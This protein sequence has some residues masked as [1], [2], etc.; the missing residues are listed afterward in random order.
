M[1]KSTRTKPRADAIPWNRKVES[2]RAEISLPDVLEDKMLIYGNKTVQDRAVNDYRDGFKPVHRRLIWTMFK[3]GLWSKGGFTKSARVTGTAMGLFHP[4]S[5]SALYEALVTL[6]NLRYSLL[7]KQG[8]WGSVTGDLPAAERYSEVKL[9]PLPEKILFSSSKSAVMEMVPNY[10]GTE[11]EPVVFIPDLPNLYLQG[12]TGIAVG[13]TAQVA[14]FTIESLQKL[15]AAAMKRSILKK[16]FV[17]ITPRDC[18]S[19]LEFCHHTGGTVISTPEEVLEF[20]GSY[21]G[22]LTWMCDTEWNERDSYL[23]LTGFPPM[24]NFDTKKR[25]IHG[26]QGVRL[27]SEFNDPEHGVELRVYLDPKLSDGEVDAVLAAVDAQ[28]TSSVTYYNN[29]VERKRVVDDNGYVTAEGDFHSWTIPET[30]N[31]WIKW[32]VRQQKLILENDA[33]VLL[34]RLYDEELILQAIDFLDE[35]VK[36]LRNKTPNFDKVA[37]LAKLMGR[38]FEDAERV[39]AI[40][41][42][43]FDRMSHTAQTKKVAATRAELAVV[44][45]RQKQVWGDTLEVVKGAS[46]S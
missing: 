8:N 36:M 42:G 6:A 24:W 18:A 45:K 38:P 32:R 27:V 41:I 30:L 20:F 21:T 26:I 16:K 7:E 28:L 15:V 11:Q 5:S 34:K 12:A 44:R 4:H 19:I 3:M 1:A 9:S 37:A 40:A 25:K 46:K 43:R 13:V 14:T 29:V 23:A 22:R 35:M 2:I 17:P 31:R 10:D 39:W 33:S